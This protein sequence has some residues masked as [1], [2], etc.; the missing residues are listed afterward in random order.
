MELGYTQHNESD[1]IYYSTGTNVKAMNRKGKEV[2]KGDT[3]SSES[4]VAF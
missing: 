4:V 2:F 1:R 3:K